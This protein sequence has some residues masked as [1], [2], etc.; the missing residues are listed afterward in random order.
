MIYTQYG[1]FSSSKYDPIKD[2]L[3]AC[4]WSCGSTD[5]TRAYFSECLMS[6]GVKRLLGCS[7]PCL[8]LSAPG[9]WTCSC[10]GT[11]GWGSLISRPLWLSFIAR[12]LSGQT[13]CCVVSCWGSTWLPTQTYPSG[14]FDC[15]TGTE[16]AASSGSH[17]A[18]CTE[19]WR[20]DATSQKTVFLLSTSLNHN[21]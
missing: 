12:G 17:S 11:P 16:A 18:S 19:P 2:F 15:F 10:P 7:C 5:R 13:L 8:S 4:P 1:Q 6:G 21:H 9:I 20:S 14:L 3:F